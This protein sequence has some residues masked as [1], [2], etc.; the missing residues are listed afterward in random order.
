MMDK[1]TIRAIAGKHGYLVE[2]SSYVSRRG[3]GTESIYVNVMQRGKGKQKKR[4]G[5]LA[6]LEVLSEDE[7]AALMVSKFQGSEG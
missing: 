6:V 5:T 2:F 7:L 3:D 1:A 4:L